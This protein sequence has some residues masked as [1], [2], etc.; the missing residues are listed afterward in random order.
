MNIFFSVK[1][2]NNQKLNSHNWFF[3]GFCKELSNC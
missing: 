2:G 3:N 1:Y